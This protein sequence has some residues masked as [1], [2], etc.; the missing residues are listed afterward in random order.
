MV[1]VKSWSTFHIF[2][3]KKHT[4]D[5]LL[6][7][8]ITCEEHKWQKA[9]SHC[10]YSTT[11]ACP[12][13]GQI[14]LFYLLWH[15]IY[16]I[17]LSKTDSKTL[18]MI[19]STLRLFEWHKRYFCGKTNHHHQNQKHPLMCMYHSLNWDTYIVQF[20]KNQAIIFTRHFIVIFFISSINSIL[21]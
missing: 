19:K 1:N 13:T 17:N 10:F 16:C 11:N 14:L 3:V 7:G 20:L 6:E 15:V 5:E 18:K 21:L 2:A 4:M 12:E 8:G 9:I